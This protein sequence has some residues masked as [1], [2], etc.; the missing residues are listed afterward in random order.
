MASLRLQRVGKRFGTATVIDGAD[1]VVGDGEFVVFVGP[2]GCGKST[3]LRMIC[4]LESVSEGDV[5]IGD[6]RVNDVPAAQRGLA[7]VFQSYA[8]YPHMTVWQNLAFGLQNLRTPASEIESR[9][10]RAAKL[11]RLDALLDRRPTQLSGGQRQRVAIGR[12]IV[13][14]PA[15]FL[16]DEPLSNL[17][18][19]LRVAMRNE[20]TAL[21]RRL[22]TTMIYVTH[23]QVEAMTMADRI[24][25]LRAGRIEQI[26][27]PLELYNRPANKFVAGFIGSPQ[28]NFLAGRVDSPTE[29]G[30]RVALDAAPEATS[31][32]IAVAGG[33]IGGARVHV[34]IRPEDIV[35]DHADGAALEVNAT[36]ER[37]EQLGTASFV[38][39]RVASGELLTVH[40]AG[41][42]AF[43]PADTLVARLPIDRLHLFDASEGER[44]MTKRDLPDSDASAP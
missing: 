30:V 32:P 37:V 1:L 39:A 8:L 38:Y 23:D 35:L 13:R 36:I 31:P 9:V 28:M 10:Q 26:G 29:A 16:F 20:I 15:I 43:R 42:R 21:H 2:S 12:A 25:V 3:L 27:A 19:E 11:L 5:F 33:V 7:M 14:E 22:R 40:V 17:D 24:V 6:A 4:G 41:Q 18:A 34:G 44:A